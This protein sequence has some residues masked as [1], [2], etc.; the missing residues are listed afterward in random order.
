L[1]CWKFITSS[2]DRSMLGDNA[3]QA[4]LVKECTDGLVGVEVRTSSHMVM[5]EQD[6]IYLF[7]L[8]FD[9]LRKKQITEKASVHEL[10]V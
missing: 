10:K 5:N 2:P 8:V 1:Y 7:T 9:G 3:E 4:I 6:I